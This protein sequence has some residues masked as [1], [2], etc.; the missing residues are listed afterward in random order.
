MKDEKKTKIKVGITVAVALILLIWI[1]GWAKNISLYSNQ[2]S[3]N[4]K[5]ENVAGLE[6]GDPVTINGVRKGFVDDI[7]V[8]Q[9]S[10]LVKLSLDKDAELKEDAQFSVIMLDLMGGKKIEIMP[11]KNDKKIDYSQIQNGRFLADVPTVMAMIGSVQSDL[12]NII[13]EVQITLGSLNEVLTDENFNSELKSSVKNLNLL[14]SK[15]NAVIEKNQNNLELLLKNST[16]LTSE[17]TNFMKE[18]RSGISESFT[19]LN[20]MIVKT[21]QLIS[22]INSVAEETSAKKNNLGKLM[23]DEELLNDLKLTLKQAKELTGILNEQ[24]KGKGI[25]VDANIDLF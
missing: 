9:N 25:N 11:G 5:F 3:L 12:I 23:Y 2:N 17:A 10:A 13:K 4:V 8:H 22:K 1:F 24:L 16:E 6:K 14:T 18:N 19:N 20:K 21:D 7:K 15:L